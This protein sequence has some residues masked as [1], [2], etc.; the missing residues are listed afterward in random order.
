MKRLILLPAA[1]LA[2]MA[3]IALQAEIADLT[4]DVG[5]TLRSSS[6]IN[7]NA[8]NDN[9][10]ST[11]VTI[12]N[13]A[14][15]VWQCANPYVV[16]QY[17]ITGGSNV[18]TNPRSWTLEASDD[19]STWVQIDRR[20][21]QSINANAERTFAVAEA[22]QLAYRY[23]RFSIDAVKGGGNSCTIAELHLLGEKA[24][25]PAAPSDI[26]IKSTDAGLGIAWRDNSDNETAFRVERSYDGSEW[27]EVAETGADETSIVDANVP[28]GIGA[29]YRVC[30]LNGMVKSDYVSTGVVKTGSPADLTD[31]VATVGATVDG[32]NP[33]NTAENGPKGSDGNL[34]T[35][36]L[37]T[38][39][40]ATLTVKLKSPVA[41][42]QY[43]VASANDAAERDP[44]NW[45]VEGSNNGSTWIEID[46]KE[47][48]YFSSRFQSNRYLITNKTAYSQ[49]RLR[50]TANA[51]SNLTQLSEFSLYADIEPATEVDDLK[52][53]TN[54]SINVRTYNQ[55]EL[56]WTDNNSN[57]DCYIVQRSTDG[58][59]WT[60]TY[61]TEPNDERCYP[62]DL[63]ANTTYYYRIA[64]KAGDSQSAWSNVVSATT[65]DDAWP[66]TWPNFNFDSGYHTGN[67]VK[68]YSNDDIAIFVNPADVNAEGVSM[69]DLDLSW[70]VEPYTKMWVAIRDTYLDEYGEHL[71]GDPRL[72]IVPHYHADGGG[73]GRLFTYRDADQL[74]RNIV[75]VSVGKNSGWRW[76]NNPGNQTVNFLY[77]VMT[78]ESGHIIESVASGK[79][80]SPFYAVWL[81]S[82]WAEIFQ[83]DIFGKMDVT[84]QTAWH[85]EYMQLGKHTESKP[86]E[87]AEWYAKWLYPT[88]RDFGGDQL[89]LRF[90][91]LMGKYYFQRNGELQGDGNLGEYIHFMS[92]AAGVDVSSYAKDAFGWCDEWQLQLLE[93]RNRYPEVTY[94]EV[95]QEGNLLTM[96]TAVVTTSATAST[97]LSNINDSNTTTAFDAATKN[98]DAEWVDVTY[99]ADGQSSLVE[100]YK[101]YVQSNKNSRPQAI[102]LYG[103]NDNSTW[104]LI[105]GI[106]S[107]DYTSSNDL[108]V[109]LDQPVNYNYFK[110]H[111]KV[112]QSK[113][114]SLAV[115]EWELQGSLMPANP[116]DLRGTWDGNVVKLSWSAPYKDIDHFELERA[117]VGDDATFTKIADIDVFDLKYT[118]SDVSAETT[119]R[120]RLREQSDDFT[121]AYSNE[122]E[123]YTGISGIHQVTI[124][125]KSIPALLD[126][127]PDNLVT[128]YAVDGKQIVSQSMNS[129]EWNVVSSGNSRVAPGVYIVTVNLKQLAETVHTKI[130]IK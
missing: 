27:A 69:T 109:L 17:T 24:V 87:G 104:T 129:A 86:A 60:R 25:A 62:Y 95:K 59:N 49:Y 6:N 43:A 26:R 70:M 10:A 122:C 16:K 93:A 101:L 42:T 124:D 67:L 89:F 48:Q 88:Y 11:D 2:F 128:F 96:E 100:S 13:G 29:L 41:V 126:R 8:L 71:V 116:S 84:H 92:G 127:N 82:K 125:T 31:V 1:A 77:D 98:T 57:E 119:Y 19:G 44:K 107:P 50:I 123:V 18:D 14:L 5:V 52:A 74:Y 79:K 23:F 117:E 105:N 61:V 118:D 4:S 90:F 121:S 113:Y 108:E 66:E 111:L 30:A 37:S 47:N 45:V 85:N 7:V 63:H 130:I 76:E 91:D 68:K 64:A 65:P 99:H 110:L 94:D 12:I 35:K 102:E 112:Y 3:P 15:I 54:L 72:Y 36:Y 51:G 34:F 106:D 40:P 9:D 97:T 33:I 46:K 81:D 39:L 114:V 73:L 58:E 55:M 21:A 53:P 75:H 56:A 80:N 32:T 115:N 103:S 28:V 22:K 38:S 83:Y 120:Y 78:H 20:V